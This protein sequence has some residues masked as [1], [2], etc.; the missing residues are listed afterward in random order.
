MGGV[1]QM[2]SRTSTAMPAP[3]LRNVRQSQ[4]TSLFKAAAVVLRAHVTGSS[5]DLV[6]TKMYGRD[7]GLDP[8]DHQS[9]QRTCFTDKPNM[10]R[11]RWSRCYF[12]SADPKDCRAVCGCWLDDGGSQGRS[13]RHRRHSQFPV[14]CT[15]RLLPAT[16]SKK[17]QPFHF[18]FPFSR[19]ARDWSRAR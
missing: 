1:Q 8:L 4:K 18:V 11:W 12:F 7:H 3:M 2:I 6:A 15:I 5:P 14:D 10:G 19:W 17:A 13:H 16:G 9:C